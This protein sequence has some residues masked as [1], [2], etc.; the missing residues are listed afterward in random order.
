MQEK[1]GLALDRPF[2]HHPPPERK[3]LPKTAIG[4]R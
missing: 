4:G 2:L 3:A 1:A